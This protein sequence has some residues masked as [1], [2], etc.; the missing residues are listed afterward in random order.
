MLQSPA[1]TYSDDVASI[2]QTLN[3]YSEAASRTAWDE[4]LATFVPDGIWEIPAL[5]KKFQGHAA[6]RAAMVE[7]TSG[8]DYGLQINAP[9]VITL[10]GDRATAR[11]A[12][13]EVGK[14]SGRD[15]LFET[16]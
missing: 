2:Q 3:Q 14:F 9:A 1:S 4:V 10:D 5:G 7:F 8:W 13:R 16:L 6:I 11:S 15:E 12:I